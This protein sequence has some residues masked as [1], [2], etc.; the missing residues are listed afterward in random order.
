MMYPWHQTAWQALNL[1]NLPHA[2]LLHG[3]QGIG[4]TDFAFTLAQTLL[5]ES[6]SAHTHQACGE[7]QACSWFVQSNHPD[8]MMVRPQ[9]L[10]KENAAAISDE[11]PKKEKSSSQEIRLEQIQALIT[12]A[13]IGS[14]RGKRKVILLYPVETLNIYAANALLKILEEPPSQIIFILLSHHIE[15]VLPTILS[16]CQQ[17]RL[18]MPN[19]QQALEWLN[20]KNIGN[21]LEILSYAGGSPL[22]ALAASQDENNRYIYQF[23]PEQLGKGKAIADLNLAEGLHKHDLHMVLQGVQRWAYD[24]LSIRLT[25]SV[26]YY[27]SYKNTLQKIAPL[28]NLFALLKFLLSLQT[29]QKYITHPLAPKLLLESTFAEYRNL[30][31]T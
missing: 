4:K 8:L 5:C 27:P 2:L 15:R 10:E 12:F 18:A 29:Q 6:L 22:Q 17:L 26:R 31:N 3:P 20:S 11:Q 1:A 23:L 24:L 25:Q 7:C 13:N 21:A 28:V 9:N 14:H 30:F 19:Q 16:R